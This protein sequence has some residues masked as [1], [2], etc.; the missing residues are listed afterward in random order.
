MKQFSKAHL[1][2]LAVV[3]PF[4]ALILLGNG[5]LTFS[6]H[7]A[8][9]QTSLKEV[10][11]ATQTATVKE[12]RAPDSQLVM[13]LKIP[14]IKVDAPVEHLG[15]TPTGDMDNPKD[16]SKAGWYKFGTRPGNQGSA[17]MA[18][19]RSW[20]L[21]GQV[22]V[23]DNLD[24]LR[25]GDSVFIEIQGGPTYSYV[26]S[27]SNIYDPEEVAPEVFSSTTG[28]HLNLIASAGTWNEKTKAATK[29]LVVF[30]DLTN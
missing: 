3:L 27:R 25:T 16:P 5:P 10:V 8:G 6:K 29:R 24:K 28:S 17:V 14:K 2:S 21:N 20:M 11:L 26:V 13:R 22:A 23:F 9:P 30:T 19:H 18:G 7:G 1:K 15:L 4:L 12:T